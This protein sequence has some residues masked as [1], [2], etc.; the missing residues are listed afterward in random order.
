MLL[1]LRIQEFKPPVRIARSRAGI[2][3]RI[4][5]EVVFESH[6]TPLTLS[7]LSA[8]PHEF[9]SIQLIENE[10]IVDLVSYRFRC[11][12]C[13]NELIVFVLSGNRLPA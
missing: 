4:P 8:D 10:R 9:D 2:S 12:Q 6:I 11:N 3:L 5:G 1:T 7:S 13:P